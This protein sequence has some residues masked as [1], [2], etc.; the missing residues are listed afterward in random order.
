[1]EFLQ[2]SLH[3]EKA[4]TK[5]YQGEHGDVVFRGEGRF[6]ANKEL[7]AE[8]AE[9]FANVIKEKL[10]VREEP[11][12]LADLGGHK[13]ELLG[14]I[15]EK[16]PEYDFK[17]I[18]V[19]LN[20]DAL[21]QNVTAVEKV[22]ASLD[23]LPLSDK[24]VDVVMA[25]YVLPWN[26]QEV[27]KNILKEIIRVAKQFAIIEHAGAPSDDAEAWRQN[28]NKLFN[29]EKVTELNGRHTQFFSSRGEIE[30]WMTE[31]GV[32][33]ERIT[34]RKVDNLSDVF[35]EKWGMGSAKINAVKNI[36]GDKDYIMQTR[37]VIY[38]QKE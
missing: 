24:S 30:D 34:E 35:I 28:L 3:Q 16:L 17:T 26:S 33:F 4:K 2:K 29:N 5:N 36:L 31:A 20:E 19:D 18:A 9:N 37:W 10:P 32:H 11:Y 6:L 15:L 8:S 14:N 25:R 21:A 22:V 23:K 7:Y 13:G 27:Q 38:P 1:M 12:V